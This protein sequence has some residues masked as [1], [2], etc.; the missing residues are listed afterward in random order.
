MQVK[1]IILTL[2]LEVIHLDLAQEFNISPAFFKALVS[3]KINLNLCLE[4][5]YVIEFCNLWYCVKR[6]K[7]LSDFL[8][9]FKS[10]S[11]ISAIYKF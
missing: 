6:K 1:K 11:T 10:Y 4:E 9:S 2:S 5:D 3:L 8:F 7:S